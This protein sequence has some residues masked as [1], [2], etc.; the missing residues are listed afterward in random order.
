MARGPTPQRLAERHLR[1]FGGGILLLLAGATG[2]AS[3]GD[4]VAVT[5]S[6][7]AIDLDGRLEEAIW[8]EAP[9]LKLTQ[10]SPQPGAPTPFETEA[11]VVLTGDNLYFGFLCRDPELRRVAVRT[12]RRDGDMQGDDTV[13]LALDT[14]GDNRTGYF[15]RINAAGVRADGLI[16]DPEHPSYD[17]DGIWEART[18]RDG[19]GWSVE[20]V[21][22]SR[23]LNFTPGRD[24]W[25]LNLERFVARD[26]ITLRWASPTLDA[27][28]YDLSRAGTL[29][30]VGEL[31]QGLGVEVSP[32]L[33]GRMT[34][35]FAR[36]PR[37]WQGAAGMD[38]AWK[39]TPQLVTVFTGNTDFAETEVDSRQVNITRFPLL[40]PEKRSF[41]L[42]G[43]NQYEFG[44]GLSKDFIPFFS[45]RIGLLGGQQVP[46]NA[47]LKLNGRAGKWNLALLDVQT[48]NSGL[49]PSVNLLAGRV[50]YD[51]TKEFRL[52]ALV[53]NGDPQGLANKTLLGLDAV[54]RSSTFRGDKNLLIGLWT[55]RNVG[56]VGPGK[57]GGWGLKVDYPNDLWDCA[58]V[59]NQF[60]D[61][62]NPALGFLPRP[63]TRHYRAKCDYQP[64]PSRQGSFAWIRQHL[65]ESDFTW[66]TNLRGVTESWRYLLAP[67]AFQTE[68]GDHFEFKWVPQFEF[69]PGP[70]EIVRGVVV[71]PGRYRFTRW[72]IAAQTSSHRT[73]QA[74]ST[75]W[76]GTFYSG[77]LTQWEQY[78]RWTSP[79]G[80]LQLGF[81][82]LNNFGHLPQGH[83]AQRL[84]QAQWALAWNPNVVLTSLIQYDTESQ[85]LG[86]NTRLRWTFKPGNDLFILWNRGWQRLITTPSDAAL[87]PDNEFL[88]VKLHW[89]FRR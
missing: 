75:T 10:Q 4:S 28:F 85:G 42:E 30:G 22:P 54:W 1:L 78:L 58:G 44:L 50:S 33:I 21:I 27:F 70:F 20:V 45:R 68:S 3:R 17:W 37:A 9:V 65:F 57:R 7:A 41:F 26:R 40:F 71:P 87:L 29:T 47:G 2:A 66:V 14:F 43:A 49:A 32:Y 36:S 76:L 80:R 60:G 12:M 83:F 5:R 35:Q 84:W 18:A 72:Q 24:Q 53:T 23:T 39:I 86:A 19:H 31:N 8:R 73:V 34:D 59:F 38:L 13:A 89:T 74:G 61:A 77:R 52:G 25:G 88:A 51:L 67:L 69:L 82:A 63:G 55:A 64:R 6:R 79:Q 16:A 81:T 15:F 11:R 48:R 56:E 46:I 62:L